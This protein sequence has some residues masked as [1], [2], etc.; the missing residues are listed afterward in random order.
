M[1]K[2]MAFA[3]LALL[4]GAGAASAAEQAVIVEERRRAG[5]GRPRDARGQGA[6]PGAWS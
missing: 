1:K 6:V 3:V 4:V 5:L 2:V